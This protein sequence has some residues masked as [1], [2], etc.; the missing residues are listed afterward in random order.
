MVEGADVPGE[1]S[2]SALGGIAIVCHCDGDAVGAA[3][4]GIIGDGSGDQA[5]G[6]GDG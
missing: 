1:R 3:V 4:I 2:L 5:G 6:G